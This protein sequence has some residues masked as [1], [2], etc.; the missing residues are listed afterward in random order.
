MKLAGLHVLTFSH[1]NETQLEYGLS[2]EAPETAY[3]M[4]LDHEESNWQALRRKRKKFARHTEQ[5]ERQASRDLGPLQFTPMESNWRPGLENL[6]K[7]KERQYRETGRS[8]VFAVAWKRQ[9]LDKLAACREPACTG[10]L[11]T[12]YA[13]NTWLASHFG[14]RGGGILHYWFPVYNPEFS[15]FGPGQLLLKALIDNSR[16]MKLALIDHG[17]GEAHY[18]MECSNGS[19]R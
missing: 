2:G 11:S 15:R 12:L 3:L 5:G 17:A 1:L 6:V 19:H 7:Y 16:E 10:M 9:L 8:S 18:K 14:L 4:H 13:G